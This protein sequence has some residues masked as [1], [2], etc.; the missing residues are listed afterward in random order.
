MSDRP[1]VL[2][3]ST[4]KIKAAL[5]SGGEVKLYV[6]VN[7]RDGKPYEVFA[8]TNNQALYEHMAAVTLMAS[9]LLQAGVDVA[10]IAKD[11]KQIHS[12]VTGHMARGGYAASIYARIGAIL[13]SEHE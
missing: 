3:G 11:F 9:R 6:T 5:P 2:S 10:T 7:R 4:H 13:E 1:E 12:P 8:N